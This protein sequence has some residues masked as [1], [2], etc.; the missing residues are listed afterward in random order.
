ML[1]GFEPLHPGGMGDNS[2]AFQRWVP[3]FRGAQVPKGR[4]KPCAASQYFCPRPLNN[5]N[6]KP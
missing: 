2:P 3:E 1:L 4:L 5:L 6:P